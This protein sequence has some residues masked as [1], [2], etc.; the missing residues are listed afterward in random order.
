MR[1]QGLLRS[2]R[3]NSADIKK[4]PEKK[5]AVLLF[6]T[7]KNEANAYEVAEA[8]DLQ[9]STSHSSIQALKKDGLL[10]LNSTRKNEKGVMA[11]S[12]RLSSKGVYYSIYLKPTWREKIVVAEKWTD[13][14]K[15]HFVDWLTFI[16]ALSDPQIEKTINTQIGF[17]LS[18]DDVGFFLDVFDDFFF[19]LQMVPEMVIFPETRTKIIELAKSYPRIKNELLNGLKEQNKWAEE[20][21]EK[22]IKIQQDLERL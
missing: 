1:K 21:L 22:Q 13:F 6:F 3:K 5:K 20:D 11:K 15:P 14:I 19:T 2:K 9:Y 7:E 12:Y 17:S 16:G 18:V 4:L 10:L 8:L